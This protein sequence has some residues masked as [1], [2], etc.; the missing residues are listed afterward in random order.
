MLLLRVQEYCS[1]IDLIENVINA[2]NSHQKE[3]SFIWS[4]NALEDHANLSFL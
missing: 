1:L 4:N 2:I 3:K